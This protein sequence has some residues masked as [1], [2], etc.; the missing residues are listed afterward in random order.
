MSRRPRLLVLGIGNPSR[1]DDALGPLLVERVGAALAE[2][3]RAARLASMAT[4]TAA[5]NN[6]RKRLRS[7][8]E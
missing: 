7:F 1:G 2:G 6:G 3:A 5:D 4:M 8:I